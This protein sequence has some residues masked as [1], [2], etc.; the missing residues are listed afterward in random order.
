MSAVSKRLADFVLY[1]GKDMDHKGVEAIRMLEEEL[2]GVKSEWGNGAGQC[3]DI[4][5]DTVRTFR[6]LLEKEGKK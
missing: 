3:A 1:S 6:K 2:Q 5:V 4:M